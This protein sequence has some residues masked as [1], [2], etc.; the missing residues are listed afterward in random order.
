MSFVSHPISLDAYPS[1][2]EL[3]TNYPISLTLEKFLDLFYDVRELEV[4]VFS[5]VQNIAQGL[6]TS[7]FDAQQV[8][9][10]AVSSDDNS[11]K[12]IAS[13]EINRV[14]IIRADGETDSRI[15]SFKDYPKFLLSNGGGRLI[16]DFGRSKIRNGLISPYI[17]IEFANG[18]GN[19]GVGRIIGG[20]SF[21]GYGEILLYDGGLGSAGYV[22]VASG[23]IAITERFSQLRRNGGAPVTQG[24]SVIFF[25]RVVLPRNDG[26]QSLREYSE[27]FAG[28]MRLIVDVS[29]DF[30]SVTIPANTSHRGPI[31][32]R[33][34]ASASLGEDEFLTYDSVTIST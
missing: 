5:G 9:D 11:L 16:I 27:A 34:P 1:N 22:V 26:L 25:E 18:V 10:S 29:N 4:S 2:F 15:N 12:G 13:R 33:R 30:L 17:E 31:L 3:E 14:G 19:T 7:I 28:P 23:R 21:G 8:I 20:V 32:F 24:S 6:P